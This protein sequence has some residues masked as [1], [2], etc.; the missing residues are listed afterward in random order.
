MQMSEH[1]ANEPEWATS[2]LAAR[3]RFRHLQIL[4]ALKETGS[5]SAAAQR[6]H[7]TQPALSKAVGEIESA[8]SHTL[9]ARTA[10]GVTPTPAGQALLQGAGLL[11]HQLAHVQK[12]VAASA[13]ATAILRIGSTS[14]IAQS[15]LPSV[16]QGLANGPAPM[17]THLVEDRAP[18]L[19]Q[20][21][22]AGEL[23]AAITTYPTRQEQLDDFRYSTL[24]EVEFIVIA[25]PSHRLASVSGT[26]WAALAAERWIMPS[27]SAMIRHE[28]HAC[29]RRADTPPP[30]PVIEAANPATC[31]ELVAAN[32]GISIVPAVSAQRAIAS[33]IVL[34]MHVTPAFPRHPVALIHME[35]LENPRVLMLLDALRRLSLA[36]RGPTA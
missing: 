6:L 23:D 13:H 35:P 2:R 7:L 26:G 14:F 11:L 15:Y 25:A 19:L 9:F 4:V 1:S 12:E 17:I 33:G 30:V 8:F 34:P 36:P 28:L 3:L 31:I 10:R 22:S 27:P 18:G 29:F 16:L 32:L 5:L 24:F 21:L 20:A